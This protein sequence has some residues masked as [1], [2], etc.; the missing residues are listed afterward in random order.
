MRCGHH[1]VLELEEY[2]NDP[3]VQRFGRPSRVFG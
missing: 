2:L 1:V 3:G